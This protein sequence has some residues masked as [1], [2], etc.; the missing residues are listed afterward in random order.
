MINK[1]TVNRQ[2]EGGG[3][4]GRAFAGLLA[5][6][7]LGV[8]LL[9][10]GAF[11]MPWMY[12][13][14]AAQAP[15]DLPVDGG[16]TSL[17]P[18]DLRLGGSAPPGRQDN[19]RGGGGVEARQI[20]QGRSQGE[21]IVFDAYRNAAA[22]AARTDPSCNLHW[23]LLAA[24]GHV[25]S[26]HAGG[27]AVQRDGDTQPPILGPQLDG[28]GDFAAISDTDA[29]RLDSDVMWDRA[30]GPMQFI[31]SSWKLMSVDGD[32]DGDANP[33]NVYDAA[34]AAA[35]YLCEG[36]RDLSRPRDR[37]LAVYGYNHSWEYVGLV[38]RLAEMYAAGS[39]TPDSPQYVPAAT[40]GADTGSS[41]AGSGESG[42]SGRRDGRESASAVWRRLRD[43]HP[44]RLPSSQPEGLTGAR[45]PGLP[46]HGGRPETAPAPGA[47]A[48]PGFTPVPAPTS[49]GQVLRPPPAPARST[50]PS[51]P[52][53]PAPAPVPSPTPTP[54][55][56]DPAPA[57]TP[58]PTAPPVP[59]PSP[60]PTCPPSGE[61]SGSA[62][63]EPGASPTPPATAAVTPSPVPTTTPGVSAPAGPTGPS[64]PPSD[65]SQPCPT[66]SLTPQAT[67]PQH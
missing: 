10:G 62:T 54:Q 36:D 6:T 19:V 14:T 61:Q 28:A 43:S 48:A 5:T 32:G 37:A 22:W 55:S 56:P 65:P 7:T 4:S 33:N 20:P 24:I 35:R 52:Q 8:V 11:G 16:G 1:P 9:I 3:L 47:P 67:P 30:V 2:T 66:A 60:Q 25:E 64:A 18:Q 13:H 51:Q 34:A 15:P 23:S 27:V 57:P 41:G 21:G 17:Q 29:G 42:W 26:H 31:P 59:T 45:P 63:P 46:P 38:L 50:P 12:S 58:T 40:G 49:E 44:D 39:L 53:P